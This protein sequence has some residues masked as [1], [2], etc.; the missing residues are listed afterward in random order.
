MQRNQTVYNNHHT[1][2]SDLYQLLCLS[3]IEQC[4][5]IYHIKPVLDS[6]YYSALKQFKKILRLWELPGLPPASPCLQYTTGRA[7]VYLLYM[8][9]QVSMQFLC[10]FQV[11]HTS[12]NPFSIVPINPVLD[13]DEPHHRQNMQNTKGK[14]TYKIIVDKWQQ[15]HMCFYT[16][17]CHFRVNEFIFDFLLCVIVQTVFV[18]CMN[19]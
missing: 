11:S 4:K 13:Y 12:I 2:S 16:E 14:A 1:V 8:S 19:I 5:Q 6:C 15:L 9:M 18:S 7:A 10:L 3:L 17:N